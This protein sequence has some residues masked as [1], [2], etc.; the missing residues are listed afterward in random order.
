MAGFLA[1]L[2]RYS[3]EAEERAYGATVPDSPVQNIGSNVVVRGLSDEEMRLFNES[4]L[5]EEP[6]FGINFGRIG[7]IIDPD[8]ELNL[9]ETLA[10]IKEQNEELFQYLRRG[11]MTMEQMIALA[12]NAGARDIVVKFMRRKPG[13]I[14]SSEDMVGGMLGLQ[15]IMFEIQRGAKAAMEVGDDGEFI[16]APEGRSEILNRI[17]V[18][19]AIRQQMAAQIS[20]NA[21][22]M[23]RGLAAL[24]NIRKLTE[25]DTSG[26]DV[27]VSSVTDDLSQSQIDYSLQAYATLDATGQWEFARKSKLAKSWDVLIE[28]HINAIIS[29]PITPMLNVA[30]NWAMQGVTLAETQ[31]AGAIGATRQAVAGKPLTDRVFMGEAA[32]EMLGMARAQ[33]DA[34]LLAG[35]AAV[36]GEPGDFISKIDL[37]GYRAIGSTDNLVEIG[38]KAVSARTQS[39]LF[40][41]SQ[42]IFGTYLRLSSR[43]MITADEYFKVMSMRRELYKQAYVA[44]ERAF[45][46]ARKAGLS[47][48]EAKQVAQNAHLE[49]LA[50]PEVVEE[51][52][53]YRARELTF[54]QTV[55]GVFGT[56][57]APD[58]AK[59][60]QASSMHPAMKPILP[61]YRTPQ[62]VINNISDRT[63]NVYP[64]IK[65]LKNGKGREFD[66][67]MA[68]FALG[69]TMFWTAVHMM[70]GLAG[71]D[72][73]V[74]GSGP[75]DYGAQQ[76]MK[77]KPSTIS[78]KQDDGSYKSVSFARLDPVSGVMHMAAD[79][80]YLSKNNPDDVGLTDA[81]I[82]GILATGNYASEL[83]FLQ[84]FAQFSRVSQPG[85]SPQER[86]SLLTQTL[87]KSYG[88]VGMSFGGQLEPIIA[89]PLRE[90][91]V[92][93]PMLGT[94]SFLA[95]LERVKFPEKKLTAMPAGDEPITKLFEEIGFVEDATPYSDL[96]PIMQGFYESYFNAMARNSAFSEELP[97]QVNFFGEPIK[98]SEER[99]DEYFNPIKIQN[100]VAYTA[101][102]EELSYLADVGYSFRPHERRYEGIPYDRDQISKYH[103]MVT[104]IDAA[105]RLPEDANYDAT[106]SLVNS[107]DAEL[108]SPSYMELESASE[109][110]NRLNQI[111]GERRRDARVRFFEEDPDFSVVFDKYIRD[112]K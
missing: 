87:A 60:M 9:A 103:Y 17:R 36:T 88:D 25:I 49:V 101:L 38:R 92:D 86:M 27:Q 83:P 79:Y 84:S 48:E 89:R 29:S 64:W 4:V 12:E 98:Q 44:E 43:A 56:G 42:D 8:N 54:Q 111:V 1:R 80:V 76:V 78:I 69:N 31:L 70:S 112:N 22:E 91:G 50:N 67:A 95:S 104:N 13:E 59:Q 47:R 74:T 68:K 15:K 18:L 61:F 96:N 82:N 75:S 97:T 110:Y 40:D 11:S 21:S 45:I 51:Q 14:F 100:D 81:A 85:L 39:E 105:G 30:G 46:T 99:T 77:F 57:V 10:K 106:T 53:K 3:K 93:V 41:V 62:N 19:A 35:R 52:M 24:S 71:D 20:A 72:V 108:Y 16:V 73:I 63:V 66:E 102:D 28:A 6:D 34:I 7:E 58:F 37:D 26:I 2:A 90:V 32:H 55:E 23:A 33:M 107:L 109:R 65:A 94:T 5:G